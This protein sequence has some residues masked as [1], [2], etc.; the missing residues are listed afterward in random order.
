[1]R[2][3]SDR[4]NPSP[5]TQSSKLSESF[6]EQ[7]RFLLRRAVSH[8]RD[9]PVGA[10][11]RLHIVHEEVLVIDQSGR[12]EPAQIFRK[13]SRHEQCEIADV[14][15][16]VPFTVHRLSLEQHFRLKQEIHHRIDRLVLLISDFVQLIGV[17]KVDEQVG[18]VS[19]DVD[20]QAI[21]DVP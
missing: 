13:Q 5:V 16:H 11:S 7:R 14:L 17:G 18:D 2:S 21:R 6:P 1:M 12:L 20:G 15:M 4:T 9:N 19:G 10:L 8:S 3:R